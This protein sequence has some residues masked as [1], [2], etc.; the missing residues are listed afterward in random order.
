MTKAKKKTELSEKR[1]LLLENFYIGGVV[2]FITV[3]IFMSYF[4]Y[5]DV[6]DLMPLRII[7]YI[8][9]ACMVAKIVLFDV[10]SY[11]KKRMAVTAV[12]FLIVFISSMIS[13]IRNLLWVLIVVI[14][15]YKTDFKRVLKYVLI[16]EIV[17]ISLFVLLCLLQIT[18]DR[19]YG[20][21]D[22]DVIRHSLGFRYATYLGLFLLSIACG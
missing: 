7:R 2:A 11:S 6:M 15:A 13:E 8:I 10:R 20:R 5:S 12:V 19:L 4:V 22:S 1:A 18:P 17:I 21:S 3:S 9:L 16:C 14:A